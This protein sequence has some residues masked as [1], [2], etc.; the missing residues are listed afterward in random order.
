M[1]RN[2]FLKR[3]VLKIILKSSEGA[4]QGPF[5]ALVH[6]PRVGVCSEVCPAQ[7]SIGRE[8]LTTLGNPLV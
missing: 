4:S 2:T 1:V 3:R 8:E 6:A 7:S 5:N